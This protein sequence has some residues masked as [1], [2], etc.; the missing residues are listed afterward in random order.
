MIVRYG[1]AV[2]RWGDQNQQYDIKS[3]T[4][5]FGATALGVAVKDGKIEL[6]APARRYHPGLGVPPE[7]NAQTGWLDE[8]TILHLATQTAGF[9]KPGGYQPLL[10]RPG[11]HWHYSDGGPNWLAE[12]ITLQYKQDLEELMFERVFTP[13]GSA[14]TTSAG[15]TTSIAST[16]LKA[17]PAVSSAR[18]S[19]RMSMHWP[20]SAISISAR[21]GG[22]TSRFSRRTL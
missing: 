21:G 11:T 8:I 7:S 17:F 19:K 3:A 5:S 1:H 13:W 16:I 18:A 14:A 22:K 15:G 4:K 20:A 2:L 6:D 12:C 10:F 9:D